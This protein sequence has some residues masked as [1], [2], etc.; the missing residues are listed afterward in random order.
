M[1]PPSFRAGLDPL[2]RG[3]LKISLHVKGGSIL[4]CPLSVTDVRRDSLPPSPPSPP[5]AAL[6]SVCCETRSPAARD[7]QHHEFPVLFGIQGARRHPG[8]GRGNAAA[9]KPA[10]GVGGTMTP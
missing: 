3:K 6:T 8:G 4:P 7:P 5:A 9:E 10:R 1:L 2:E